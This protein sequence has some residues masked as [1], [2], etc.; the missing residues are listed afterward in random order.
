M[1]LPQTF[2]NKP[3]IYSWAYLDSKG[4]TAGLVA[5]YQNGTDSKDIVPYFKPNGTGFGMGIDINPRP[6]YG[7]DKLSTHPKDKPVFIVEGEKSATALHGLGITAVSSIG[8]SNAADKS[9]WTALNGFKSVYIF[10]DYDEAGLH[11]AKSVYK[12]L[13]DLE[14][15]PSHR[16]N[17]FTCLGCLIKVILWTGFRITRRI[18]AVINPFQK[19]IRHGCLLN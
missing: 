14:S 19:L 18:G 10:P 17:L 15:P 2:N 6:L 13:T 5:R 9:D 8:G 12:A 11:Y 16:L 1:T 3:L 7:L 4:K